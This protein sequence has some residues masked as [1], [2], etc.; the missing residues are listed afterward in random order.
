MVSISQTYVIY[1]CKYCNKLFLTL[2]FTWLWHLAKTY[3]LCYT[4]T[5]KY[6]KLG[7][8]RTTIDWHMVL[9]SHNWLEHG[10]FSSTKYLWTSLPHGVES[11][12]NWIAKRWLT[13]YDNIGHTT[14]GMRGALSVN[15]EDTDTSPLFYYEGGNGVGGGG[16]LITWQEV[17]LNS[18]MKKVMAWMRQLPILCRLPEIFWTKHLNIYWELRLLCLT[19]SSNCADVI[20]YHKVINFSIVSRCEEFTAGDAFWYRISTICPILYVQNV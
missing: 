10:G 17:R 19:A 11:D 6:I 1:S 16:V 12:Q 9:Q 2:T 5:V 7:R 3:Q 15:I 13:K 4:H 8:C 14:S 20:G 18:W